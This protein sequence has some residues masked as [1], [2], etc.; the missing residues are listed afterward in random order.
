MHPP[1]TAVVL[2]AGKGTR[3]KSSRA[4]VLH[5]VFFQPMVHHVLNT[6]QETGIDRCVVIVGHQRQ[7]VLRVLQRVF[8]HPGGA[9]RSW[10][11]GTP[12]SVQKTLAAR[13]T[14]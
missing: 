9:E 3:M 10:G 1:I 5:E 7:E 4:K 14:W 12:F 8:D 13:Q 11:P 2:A 6:I